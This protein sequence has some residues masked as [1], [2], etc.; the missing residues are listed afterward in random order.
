MG[1]MKKTGILVVVFWA[2][3][4]L[5]AYSQDNLKRMYDKVLK[6]RDIVASEEH[7]SDQA[8]INENLTSR[9]DVY[10]LKLPANKKN[11]YSGT[12]LIE[13]L[14]SAFVD[15]RPAAVRESSRSADI[16]MM[17][18]KAIKVGSA[19]QEIII[20]AH[21]NSNYVLMVFPA[22]DDS[23]G[24]YREVYAM[25]WL[26]MED[27][28]TELMLVFDRGTD[29][30]MKK[31][32][33]REVDAIVQWVKDFS[34]KCQMLRYD[35]KNI[36]KGNGLFYNVNKVYEL[37]LT[38]PIEDI[39]ERRAYSNEVNRIASEISE[40]LAKSILLNAYRKLEQNR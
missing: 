14:R 39:M 40:P 6:N 23:L 19:G 4:L 35:I 29:P 26:T 12:V 9:T 16:S 17:K 5:P 22:Q 18:P 1:L 34:N 13:A 15:D 38:C 11:N 33:S 27:G 8:K 32:D 10:Y 25:E 37:C 28:F 20:G 31:M 3:A 2:M 30:N 21:Q 36:N 7:F 24:V